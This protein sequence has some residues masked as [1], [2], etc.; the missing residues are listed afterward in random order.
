MHL[1]K[2]SSERASEIQ[3]STLIA[4]YAAVCFVI[5][6]A[7]AVW[8]A[9]LFGVLDFDGGA[10]NPAA[11]K[12]AAKEAAQRAAAQQV[13]ARQTALEEARNIAA[14]ADRLIKPPTPTPQVDPAES[15]SS[16]A[17]AA[18]DAKPVAPATAKPAPQ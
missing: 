6:V 16:A 4:W 18:S 13:Q 17:S 2:R 11:Y 8:L 7:G 15:S 1:S 14:D 10:T 5:C 12:A 9:S 3:R